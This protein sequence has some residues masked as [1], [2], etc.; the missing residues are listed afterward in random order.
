MQKGVF[1]HLQ[2]SRRGSSVPLPVARASAYSISFAQLN[3][4]ED[5][6]RGAPASACS[7]S[8][9]HPAFRN[10]S[11]E[12][13]RETVLRPRNRAFFFVEPIFADARVYTHTIV[14]YTQD[15]PDRFILSADSPAARSWSYVCA[16]SPDRAIL[17][18]TRRLPAF[19]M[20]IVTLTLR[21]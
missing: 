21:R 18:E 6:A 14:K 20:Q 1:R 16:Y 19:G 2:K 4:R 13:T 7:R 11:R 5:T 8:I 3:F 17:W 15:L 10:P 9:L 12:G